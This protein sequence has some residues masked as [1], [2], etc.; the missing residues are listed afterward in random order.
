MPELF[1]RRVRQVLF[2][3][4][5]TATGLVAVCKLSVCRP[6]IVLPALLLVFAVAGCGRMAYAPNG[7]QAAITLSPEQ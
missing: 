4:S 7:Q 5:R 3:V 2:T 6:A 1:S